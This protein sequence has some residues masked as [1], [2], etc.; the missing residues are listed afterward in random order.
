VIF[1]IFALSFILFMF[2]AIWSFLFKLLQIRY[3]G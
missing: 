3:L 2:D 1:V